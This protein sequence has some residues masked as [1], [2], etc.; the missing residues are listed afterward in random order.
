[1]PN[2][3]MQMLKAVQAEVTGEKLKCEANL[4]ILLSN[5]VGI[6][7]HCD[8]V[9]EVHSLIGKIVEAEDKLGVIQRKIEEYSIF[10]RYPDDRPEHNDG[11]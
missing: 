5:S 3:G 11:C 8:I 10:D 6:G 1:M 2:L 4:G 7:E 9:S